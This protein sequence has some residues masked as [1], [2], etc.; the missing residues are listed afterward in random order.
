MISVR[1][2]D[3]AVVSICI[4]KLHYLYRFEQSFSRRIKYVPTEY[5]QV[6]P[7]TKLSFRT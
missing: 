2:F 6:N 5:N 7:C 1:I 4:I 3:L